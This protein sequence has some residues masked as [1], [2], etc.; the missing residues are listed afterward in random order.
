MVAGDEERTLSVSGAVPP[1]LAASRRSGAQTAGLVDARYV[2]DS[3]RGNAARNAE[4]G[5]E[6]GGTKHI[7]LERT[8]VLKGDHG[9][10]H[11]HY[12]VHR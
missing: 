4:S 12:R 8:R 3:A 11:M 5:R 2:A 10:T 7:E 9:V 6:R 1:G